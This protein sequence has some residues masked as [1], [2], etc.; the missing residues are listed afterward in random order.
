[1]PVGM[2]GAAAILGIATLLSSL[3]GKG[4]EEYSAG[5][6]HKDVMAFQKEALERGEKGKREERRAQS[7][8]LERQEEK[9]QKTTRDRPRQMLQEMALQQLMT[10]PGMEGM[11][12]QAM[13]SGQQA[14]LQLPGLS[15]L[16]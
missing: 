11:F 16:L 13:Q 4:I 6:R 12:A 15:N 3:F 8:L 10:R 5:G 2:A 9:I 14:P 7:M 1:M